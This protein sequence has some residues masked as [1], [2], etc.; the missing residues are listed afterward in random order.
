[1]PRRRPTAR[2]LPAPRAA[3]RRVPLLAVA[4]L[5][6]AGWVAVVAGFALDG[7]TREVVALGDRY[8]RAVERKD[9]AGALAT[10]T[11]EARQRWAGWVAFQTGNRYQVEAL[12]VRSPTLLASLF[13]GAGFTPSEA[14]I[15]ARITLESGQPWDRPAVTVVPLAIR[16]GRLLFTEP[17]FQPPG[18][19]SGP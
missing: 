16:D 15:T 8:F 17:P 14:S 5:L 6:T 18:Q 12:A 11:P 9:L 1:M 2:P 19:A 3:P 13:G 4:V 7:S 10:L